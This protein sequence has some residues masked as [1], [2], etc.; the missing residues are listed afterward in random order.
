MVTRA[1]MN[2]LIGI[3]V[4]NISL[5]ILAGAL[6]GIFGIPFA[7]NYLHQAGQECAADPACVTEAEMNLDK[8]KQA[9]KWVSWWWWLLYPLGVLMVF[10]RP[11]LVVVMLA[12]S[13]IPGSGIE[14][15]WPEKGDGWFWGSE[16]CA[17][18]G[19][20]RRLSRQGG[21]ACVDCGLEVF[22]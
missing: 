1:E 15:S 17:V 2:D 7:G 8:V 6:I 13:R 4:R 9:V 18:C 22:N 5:A 20:N 10:W 16:P 11:V 19:D 12:A 3:W 21:Y 14:V